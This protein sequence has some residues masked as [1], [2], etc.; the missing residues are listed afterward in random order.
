MVSNQIVT[1]THWDPGRRMILDFA[2]CV[3]P[4]VRQTRN[5]RW[6]DDEVGERVRAYNDQQARLRDVLTWALKRTGFKELPVFLDKPK[7]GFASSFWTSQA[8]RADLSNFEK[9]A[10]DMCNK[11]IYADD[12]KIF[13]RGPGCKYKSD[14]LSMR[15]EVWAL[16][17]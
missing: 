7:I 3:L 14:N 1:I 15:I 13:Q 2:D 17:G 6:R 9:A 12:V 4:Y 8:G 5:S 11:V 16:D 10:E